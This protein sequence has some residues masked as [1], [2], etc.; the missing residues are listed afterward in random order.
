MSL[1]DIPD[2]G[3]VLLDANIIIYAKRGKSAQCRRRLE[4]C[5]NGDVR[6]FIAIIAAAEFCHRRMMQEAQSLGL[7]ASNPARSLGQDRSL[8][9]R[10]S[11]YRKDVEDLLSGDLTLLSLEAEDLLK[12]L[13]LQRLHGLMTNDSLQAAAAIR[14]GV[15]IIASNDPHFDLIPGMTTFKP[16]DFVP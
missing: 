10:L 5:A 3:S 9:P 6:G 4:R 16:N 1:N 2:G 8:L 11:Q 15:S 7:A 12:A 13:E 14:A